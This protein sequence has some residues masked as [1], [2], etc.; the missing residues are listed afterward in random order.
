MAVGEAF[1]YWHGQEIAWWYQ[2]ASAYFNYFPYFKQWQKCLFW[3]N[4]RQCWAKCFSFHYPEMMFRICNSTGLLRMIYNSQKV[5]LTLWK[6]F[7]TFVRGFLKIN[8][9]YFYKGIIIA[10]VW[11]AHGITVFIWILC[12]PCVAL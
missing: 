11:A 1:C 5:A 3:I 8:W 6:K 12:P 7:S 9:P 4:K 10:F 2:N